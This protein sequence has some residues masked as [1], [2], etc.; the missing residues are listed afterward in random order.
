M[1]TEYNRKRWKDNTTATLRE[2]DCEVKVGRHWFR[3]VSRGEYSHEYRV[4]YVV[5]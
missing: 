2:V 3:T 4:M 1:L 5:W